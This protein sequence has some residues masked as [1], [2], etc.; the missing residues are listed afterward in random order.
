ADPSRVRRFDQEALAAS[1]LNHPNIVTVH[2]AGI[3]DGL[4]FIA[5]EFIEGQTLRQLIA[6]GP[7]K[8]VTVLDIAIQ[9]SSGLS[10]AHA[11]GIIHRDIKPENIMIRPDGYVKVLD[12]GLAKL[13]QQQ[14]K[15]YTSTNQGVIRGTLPYMSPEQLRGM[16]L[17][18]R[19]DIWS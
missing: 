16:D 2:E 8:L 4:R 11:A 9:I 10:A 7:P 18:G 5:M 15:L 14:R 12:F 19:T 3:V 13:T 1:A 6:S 17:D